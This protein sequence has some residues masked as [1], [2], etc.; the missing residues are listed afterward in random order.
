M[1]RT[2]ISVAEAAEMLQMDEATIR[3]WIELQKLPIGYYLK[4]P[5]KRRGMYIIY[6]DKVLEFMGRSNNV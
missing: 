4:K 6:L 1:E 5:N 3:F 2:R